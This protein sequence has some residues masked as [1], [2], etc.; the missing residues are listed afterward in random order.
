MS[1][2]FI[3][4]TTSKVFEVVYDP[5]GDLCVTDAMYVFRIR[6][7]LDPRVILGLIHSRLMLFLYRVANQGD[8]RVIPQVKAAKVNDIP[9]PVLATDSAECR[10]LADVVDQVGAVTSRLREARM[11]SDIEALRRECIGLIARLDHIVYDLYGLT[12]DEIDLVESS[13]SGP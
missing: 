3:G 13:T 5:T 9:V 10:R 7:G 1:P 11:P 4:L 12:D 8:G 2:K 6:E